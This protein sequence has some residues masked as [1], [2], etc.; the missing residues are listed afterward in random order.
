MW[1]PAMRTQKT[2]E[3]NPGRSGGVAILV[4]AGITILKSS[5]ESDHRLI[6][7]SIGW[8]RRKSIHIMSIYGYNVGPKES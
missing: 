7:A 8:G 2:E 4:W 6:G 1:H 5:L 3:G